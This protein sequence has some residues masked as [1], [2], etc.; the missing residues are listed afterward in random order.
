MTAPIPADVRAALEAW[1]APPCPSD[2]NGLNNRMTAASDAVRI[3][4]AGDVV[5]A[6][7]HEAI[8]AWNRRAP[9]VTREEVV[10][11]IG[12]NISIGITRR[13]GV[14]TGQV[15]DIAPAADAVLALLNGESG[16]G[17]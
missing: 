1:F 17:R 2:T 9:A 16:D 11:A 14:P 13:K 15:I 10:K 8:A 12:D 4:G 5:E 6:L 7:L 3:A